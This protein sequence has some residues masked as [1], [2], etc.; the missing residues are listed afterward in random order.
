MNPWSDVLHETI[1]QR[2]ER[3]SPQAYRWLDRN[4]SLSV[5]PSVVASYFAT[6]EAQ[7]NCIVSRNLGNRSLQLPNEKK[8]WLPFHKERPLRLEKVGE[9]DRSDHLEG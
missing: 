6:D 2:V 8:R 9:A 4:F 5:P 3:W 1:T 7:S